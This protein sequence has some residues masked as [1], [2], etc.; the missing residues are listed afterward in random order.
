[1]AR[2]FMDEISLNPA[3]WKKRLKQS[4][5]IKDA[6]KPTRP[7]KPTKLSGNHQ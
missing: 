6:G 4:I 2:R 3:L 5:I 7:R 1:M